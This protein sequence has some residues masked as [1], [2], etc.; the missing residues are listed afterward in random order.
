MRET[1]FAKAKVITNKAEAQKSERKKATLTMSEAT[2]QEKAEITIKAEKRGKI[3]PR[4]EV[5]KGRGLIDMQFDSISG[6][7][8]FDS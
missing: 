5:A 3:L 4:R 6:A 2:Q 8:V 1:S 7:F